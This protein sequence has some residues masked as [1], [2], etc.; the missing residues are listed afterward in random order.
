MHLND[1]R[2][3]HRASDII[4]MRKNVSCFKLSKTG[5]DSEISFSKIY[6]DNRFKV[7]SQFNN[8]PIVVE[9][10]VHFQSVK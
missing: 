1:R 4:K 7:D 10:S 8:L 3:L 2:Y 9:G 6:S 5:E